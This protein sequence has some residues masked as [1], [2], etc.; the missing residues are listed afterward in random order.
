MQIRGTFKKD[1]CLAPHTWFQVG[2]NCSVFFKPIDLDDLKKFLWKNNDPV[3]FL[4]AGSNLI[5]RDGGI[6]G[7]VIKL[8]SSFFTQIVYDESLVIVGGG[9][10]DRTVSLHMAQNGIGGMEFLATIPGTMG[11]AAAMNAGA[12]GREIVELIQWIELLS[13]QGELYRLSA[14]E[15]SMTYR[16]GNLPSGHAITRMA[17]KGVSSSPEKVRQEIQRLTN[18]RNETQPTQSRTGG[19][20][21]KNPPG[22]K[23]W[24][25]IDQAGC[26]GMT[27]GPV[28]V[29]PKHCN[30][31]INHAQ[32]TAQQIETLGEVVRL[33]V[34][35]TTGIHLDWEIIRIG[36][37]LHNS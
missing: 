21:F 37:K 1:Y 19:S 22:L 17:L 32:A 27:E 5:I 8:Q 16:S 30:F 9:A 14:S 4:G 11:G 10:L 29:S 36:K 28:Q 26:R 3:F 2:G 7:A 33:K 23:A 6:E 35:E 25:L 24:E 15:L 12:Y 13:P 34:Q 31:L 18:I 20:T